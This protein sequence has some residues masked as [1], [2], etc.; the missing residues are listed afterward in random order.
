[1]RGKKALIFYPV[2][3]SR[4]SFVLG[5]Y[6][7]PG[8]GLWLLGLQASWPLSAL[9]SWDASRSKRAPSWLPVLQERRPLPGLQ[10]GLLSNARNEV[11][12]GDVL[13]KAETLLEGGHL[14]GGDSRTSEG[15]LLH[16]CSLGFYAVGVRFWGVFD[17]SL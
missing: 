10:T 13:T 2:G 14:V 12:R 15:C 1:M 8:S 6:Q 16:G 7:G 4:Q 5:R 17:Q 11:V 9:R 3:A